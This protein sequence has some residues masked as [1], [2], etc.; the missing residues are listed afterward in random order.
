MPMWAN[1]MEKIGYA[2]KSKSESEEDNYFGK[3][4]ASNI[5]GIM[6]GAKLNRLEMIFPGSWDEYTYLQWAKEGLGLLS[7]IFSSIDSA[8]SYLKFLDGYKFREV[9][10]GSH[11][12]RSKNY[13]DLI[14]S[15]QD[16]SQKPAVTNFLSQLSKL[17]DSDSSVYFTSCTAGDNKDRLVDIAKLL[18][19]SVYGAEGVNYLGFASSKG[20]FWVAKPDGTFEYLGKEPPFVLSFSNELIPAIGKS[21][22]WAG[23]EKTAN[24][25]AKQWSVFKKEANQFVEKCSSKIDD[26]VKSAGDA[27]QKSKD[28][29]ENLWNSW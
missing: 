23:L 8:S 27:Y 19:C 7:P 10:V 28:F 3:D 24:E 29:M 4:I 13:A 25:V 18:N 22:D 12:S 21:L 6:K 16:D 9:I 20:K 5:L 14:G 11:G 1:F 17:V 15:I 2:P 26:A